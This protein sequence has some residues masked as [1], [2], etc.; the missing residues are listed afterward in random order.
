MQKDGQ[1]TQV[2]FLT[3]AKKPFVGYAFKL[4]ENKFGQLTFVRVYQGRLKKGDYL[5]NMKTRKRVKVARM[6]KMHA[7]QMEEISEVEAGDI[8]AIF[9]VDCSS[10]DTLVPGDMSYQALCSS[11]FVPQPVM[12]LSIKP[13]KKEYSA[14]F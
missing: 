2:E 5:Y 1:E 11:M 12:S 14:K 7:N 9:G 8:F 3:D 4:E 6:A 13:T 10:G